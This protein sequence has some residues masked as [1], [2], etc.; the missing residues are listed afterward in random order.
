M[1]EDAPN[2]GFVLGYAQ[3]SWTLGAEATAVFFSRL[4][5]TMAQRGIRVVTPRKGQS[6][7]KALPFFPLSSTY[8]QKGWGDFPVSG[9]G[10][11]SARTE[12][13][14]DIRTATWSDVLESME[15][16]L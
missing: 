3:A 5:T 15:T 8:I 11:W 2:L 16:Q 14:K 4:W 12:Y 13:F 7:S 9:E 6:N 1:L 10:I